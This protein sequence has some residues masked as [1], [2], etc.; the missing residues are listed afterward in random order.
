MLISLSRIHENSFFVL[1]LQQSTAPS[2][3]LTW[4]SPSSPVTTRLLKTVCVLFRPP[5]DHSASV[6]PHSLGFHLLILS[7][8]CLFHSLFTC[9]CGSLCSLFLSRGTLSLTASA[10]AG[11]HHATA[12]LL[13]TALQVTSVP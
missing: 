8:L 7:Y 1:T 5:A 11:F 10:T 2:R 12:A 6:T 9:L 3:P 13:N 4:L